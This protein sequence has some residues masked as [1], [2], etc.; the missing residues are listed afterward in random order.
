[1]AN[2]TNLNSGNGQRIQ[3]MLEYNLI[4]YKEE[5]ST[6]GKIIIDAIYAFEMEHAEKVCKKL[7]RSLGFAYFTDNYT[8]YEK[9]LSF[10]SERMINDILNFKEN[11]EGLIHDSYK[12]FKDFKSDSP[13]AFLINIVSK[14]D[15]DLATFLKVNVD[16]I[17]TIDNFIG[18]VGLNWE[19]YELDKASCTNLISKL[20]KF[21]DEHETLFNCPRVDAYI[22]LFEKNGMI[23]DFKKYYVMED[24]TDEEMD[25][26]IKNNN[27]FERNLSIRDIKLIAEMDKIIKE[28][29]NKRIKRL[30]I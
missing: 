8:H 2:I 24:T 7:D 5:P 6:T 29:N 19:F 18:M 3:K 28:N 10:F 14:Y 26:I 23:N 13:R 16:V 12:S 21:Y 4:K 20:D 1:M 30:K 15:R 17:N 22:Y 25:E 11:T 27:I 9:S